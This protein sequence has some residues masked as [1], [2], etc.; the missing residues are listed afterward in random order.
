MIFGKIYVWNWK[1]D[2]VC[3]CKAIARCSG[4][5]Y[6][7][8][9]RKLF[10]YKI[11]VTET[12]FSVPATVMKGFK[13]WATFIRATFTAPAIVNQALSWIDSSIFWT[14]APPVSYI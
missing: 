1:K 13:T 3:V 6:V 5:N 4:E 7:E 9:I 12:Q 14:D 8:Q 11:F 2:F 10:I